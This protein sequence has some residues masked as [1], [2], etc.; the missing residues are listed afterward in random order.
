MSSF[1]DRLRSDYDRTRDSTRDSPF[2]L[3]ATNRHPISDKIANRERLRTSL[4]SVESALRHLPTHHALFTDQTALSNNTSYQLPENLTMGVYDPN[5]SFE[6]NLGYAEIILGIIMSK[7]S[8]GFKFGGGGAGALVGA[9]VVYI[10]YGLITDGTIRLAGAAVVDGARGLSNVLFSR[11]NG[12]KYSENSNKKPN[13]RTEP[14][15]LKE[16][17]TLEE[18]KSA[19]GKRI[20]KGKIKDPRFQKDWKKMRYS[21]TNSDGSKIQ[22]HFWEHKITG[23]RMG[24]K[25]KNP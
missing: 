14:K 5:A 12:E 3:G 23:K 4:H 7:G 8:G 20:M 2:G 21:H 10:G 11:N 18:A 1:Y 16:K 24:F 22:I 15:N 25:F 13:V 17:L 6:T 19:P 9:A